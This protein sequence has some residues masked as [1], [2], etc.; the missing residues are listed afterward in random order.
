MHNICKLFNNVPV[1]NNINLIIEQSIVGLAGPSGSGK[2]TLLRCIQK[3][4]VFRFW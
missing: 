4:E 3:L 1:L 2:S